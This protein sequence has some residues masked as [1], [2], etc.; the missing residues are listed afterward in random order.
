[1]KIIVFLCFL[2]P[3][4][5]LEGR[6]KL[7]TVD[8]L[9]FADPSKTATFNATFL[10]HV[11]WAFRMTSH[12]RNK[13]AGRGVAI[14]RV[15]AQSMRTRVWLNLIGPRYAPDF[16]FTPEPTSVGKKSLYGF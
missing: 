6:K 4:L 8:R 1:M 16:A 9:V 7:G 12:L 5:K 11:A 15:R 14:T 13:I 2:F 3:R 10:E